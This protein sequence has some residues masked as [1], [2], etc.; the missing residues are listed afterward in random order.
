MRKLLIAACLSMMALA[1][2][3]A[4]DISKKTG[5]PLT[6]Q[7]QKMRDCSAEAKGKG[8]K[9]DERKA[10]MKECL[11]RG[12]AKGSGP[13]AEKAAAGAPAEG[14]TESKGPQK[15]KMKACNDEAKS[16]G[17]SGNE[18]KAFMGDCLKG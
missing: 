12:K 5:K 10:Y 13:K 18:R 4:N 1:P 7:Q 2:A 11:G 14:A 17:L 9:K 16:K 8:L 6:D 3:Y 15:G